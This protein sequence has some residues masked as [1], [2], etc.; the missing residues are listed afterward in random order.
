MVLE[1][2][3]PEHGARRATT[4][5]DADLYRRAAACSRTPN[6]ENTVCDE[7]AERGCP[8]DCGLCSAHQQHSCLVV[9]EVTRRCDLGCPVCL[10][11]AGAG[12]DLYAD[13]FQKLLLR[14]K[15]LEGGEVPLQLSG[16]EPTAHPRIEEL[17]ALASA[18]GF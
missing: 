17:V 5:E 4:W 18:H 14:L 7:T 10:A 1:L 8:L 15:R 12:E 16:G 2:E 6:R 3:C 11:D 13:E 9:L